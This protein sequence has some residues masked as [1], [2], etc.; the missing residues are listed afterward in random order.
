M[1]ET[2]G[3]VR[4]LNRY[5]Q[6]VF[7]PTLLLGSVYSDWAH[8]QEWKKRATKDDELLNS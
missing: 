5:W 8:T 1:G 7:F 6:I 3:V 4:L 2:S